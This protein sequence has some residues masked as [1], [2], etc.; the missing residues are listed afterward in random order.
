MLS[1]IQIAFMGSPPR[2]P[3][4]RSIEIWIILSSTKQLDVIS[5]AEIN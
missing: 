1:Y 4:Q 3:C 2:I 5:A